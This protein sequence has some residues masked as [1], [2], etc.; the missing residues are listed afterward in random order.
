MSL[1]LGPLDLAEILDLVLSYFGLGCLRVVAEVSHKWH[2]RAVAELIRLRAREQIW[3]RIVF[4]MNNSR[5]DPIHASCSPVA[6]YC[7][8]YPTLYVWARDRFE[9]SDYACYCEQSY[10]G[11][12]PGFLSGRIRAKH[13]FRKRVFNP[14]RNI[15]SEPLTSY[16]LDAHHRSAAGSANEEGLARVREIYGARP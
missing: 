3:P 15:I 5:D 2:A 8:R 6:H 10:C 12:R 9:C 7:G 14:S 16:M 4:Q 1:A 11:F 13:L